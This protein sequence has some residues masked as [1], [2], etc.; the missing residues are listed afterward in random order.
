[1]HWLV[2]W[3][4]FRRQATGN[5]IIS[6]CLHKGAALI[7]AEAFGAGGDA[8]LR[9]NSHGVA[10]LRFTPNGRDIARRK[11]M[12][13]DMQTQ[14]LIRGGGSFEELIHGLRTFYAYYAMN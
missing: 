6:R 13:N 1:M 3:R 7:R 11:S 4:T 5:T 12:I 14:R 9:R 2:L 8:S 10:F